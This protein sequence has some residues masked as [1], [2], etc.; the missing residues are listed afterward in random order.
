MAGLTTRSHFQDELRA[1]EQAA[2]GGLDLEV[3]RTV[4][5]RSTSRPDHLQE[6]TA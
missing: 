4:R 5:E 6:D 3:R 2:L 1:L